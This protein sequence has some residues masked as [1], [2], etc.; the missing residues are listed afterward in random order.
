MRKILVL[1]AAGAA[2][3]VGVPAAV[4]LGD[5]PTSNTVNTPVQ[6]T[7]PEQAQPDRERPNGDD[8]PE[9]DGRGR[10]DGEQGGSAAPAPSTE[11][12]SI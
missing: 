1:A 3:A 11:T 8:C 6:N 9:K 7:Q 10:G 12:P 4:A 5:S 2:L